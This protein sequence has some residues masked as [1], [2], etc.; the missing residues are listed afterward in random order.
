MYMQQSQTLAQG[1]LSPLFREQIALTVAGSNQCNYCASA[2]TALAKSTGANTDE[3]QRNLSG[4]SEDPETQAGLSFAK[5][6][7]E[8]RGHISD[9]ALEEVRAAGFS[10][11]EIVEIIAHIG[12]NTFTN[13][14]NHIAEPEIDFPKV[15]ANGVAHAA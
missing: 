4:Q 5:A 2:H 3:L 9:R 15:R 1:A 11:Q 8:Q 12:L 10:E 7:V 6:I 13:Y 14:F